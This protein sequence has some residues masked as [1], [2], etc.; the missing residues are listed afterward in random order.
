MKT[1]YQHF[2]GIDVS[3]A[4]IDVCVIVNE[5]KSTLLHQSFEQHKKGFIALKKW[6]KEVTSK[7]IDRLFLCIENTGLYDDALLH[8]LFEEGFAVCLE[9]ASNIKRSVRDNR[10]K[11]D[12]LDAQNIAIYALKHYD[13]LKLWEKPRKR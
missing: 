4:T 12:K 5:N 3:K 6:L 2:A 1:K 9:N 11:T 7:Q 10:G 8:Y 13:E